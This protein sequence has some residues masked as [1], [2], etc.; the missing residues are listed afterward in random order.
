[1]K[2]S[3]HFLIM[4]CICLSLADSEQKKKMRQRAHNLLNNNFDTK[5]LAMILSMMTNFMKNDQDGAIEVL[6]TTVQSFFSS[7]HNDVFSRSHKV[8]TVAPGSGK[9]HEDT[10]EIHPWK[11]KNASNS[12]RANT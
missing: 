4:G 8:G 3:T 7:T 1:M 11:A 6:L 12:S 9:L 2:S 5:K 10:T